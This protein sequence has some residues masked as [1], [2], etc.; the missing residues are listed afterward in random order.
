MATQMGTISAV[1]GEVFARNPQ[2]QVRRLRQGDPVF[3]GDVVVTSLGGSAD[4][5]PLAQGNP[6]HIAEGK[7]VGLDASVFN[8][9][10]LDPT[11]H[12]LEPL[13]I[14]QAATVIQQPAN[15]G[16]I[17]QLLEQEAAAAGLQGG[18][19][20]SGHSFVDLV[21][22]AE[23][24]APVAYDFPAN[25]VG[26]PP[27]IDGLAAP[28]PV[29]TTT[30]PV[31]AVT[32][33]APPVTPVTPETP[34]TPP[35]PTAPGWTGVAPSMTVYE[36]GLASG[37]NP[38]DTAAP[39]TASGTSSFTQGSGSFTAIVF[40][41]ATPTLTGY[42]GEAISWTLSND[43]HTL[44]GTVG[45]T[46]SITLTLMPN[47]VTGGFS[48]STTLSHAFKEAAG[49]NLQISGLGIRATD[50][51]GLSAQASAAV[52]VID[53]APAVSIYEGTD[54]ADHSATVVVGGTVSGHWSGNFGADGMSTT[55]APIVTYDGKDY[56][57]GTNIDTGK[58]TLTVNFDGSWTFVAA[59]GH[60]GET[61][62]FAIRVT[63]NDGDRAS[64]TMAISIQGA[65]TAPTAPGW[66][67]VAPSMT[68]YEAGLASGTNPG[69]TAAPITAS[70]T[71]S[72]TQGSGSFT[73]IVFTGAT[74]T[75]TGYAGEA[76][77]W[78]LSN[79][80]H[81]LTGTV[82]GTPS[83]TLTLMPN[84]VTGGFSVSTTLSH[85]FK[86]AAGAN[87]QISGLGIRATDS[88]GLSAQA[89]A[90]VTVID[91]APA[92]SIYEGTD[93]ADHSATVVVGG[94]VSG[95]WSGNFGADGMSTTFAPI[96]TYDGKDY[97]LGTNIDTGKGTLTVNFDGSW[98]F[99]AAAGHG[100][101]TV[102]FAIRVTDNDGDRASS[103]MAISIQGAPTV[104]TIN[105]FE[106]NDP[107]DH[108][109][110]ING[111]SSTSGH[112]TSTGV[113]SGTVQVQYGGQT[114]ALGQDI[115]TEYGTLRVNPDG[116][117]SFQ[118]TSP[119][120]LGQTA[121]PSFTLVA[122]DGDGDSASS[123]MNI[124]ISGV[125][126]LNQAPT[127]S[128]FGCFLAA[129]WD[130]H[131]Q[132]GT[133]LT[134]ISMS[135]PDADTVSIQSARIGAAGSQL[136][137]AE[138]V[139]VLHGQYL[140]VYINAQTGDIVYA[141]NGQA[142]P[143]N[144]KE[145]ISYTVSDEHGATTS[146][147]FDIDVQGHTQA[148]TPNLNPAAY[149]SI[150]G[151]AQSAVDADMVAAGF[152]LPNHAPEASAVN[153]I[154][155]ESWDFRVSQGVSMSDSDSGDTPRVLS[156][157]MGDW[158]MKTAGSDGVI[159]LHGQ[160]ADIYIQSQTGAVVCTWNGRAV[161]TGA[162]E[163]V[164][165]TVTDEHGATSSA[166]FDV[167]IQ[168]HEQAGVP[169]LESTPYAQLP[170]WAQTHIQETT[171]STSASETLEGHLGADTFVWTLGGI[172][173]ADRP[174]VDHVT[175]FAAGDTLQ[176]RDLLS[177]GN[178]LAVTAGESTTIAISDSAHN[179]VQTIVL[180]GYSTDSHTAELLRQT[181]QQ[182]QAY[183]AGG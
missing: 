131:S 132:A 11:A 127:T 136:A 120:A 59:A 49:A 176:L 28:A 9:A 22:I 24:V 6:L 142:V 133:A 58:G 158:S 68:V 170:S 75:L 7:T 113:G 80:G 109:A 67:G 153:V 3:E 57:L 179:V 66:T 74:P 167:T 81:T 117:W 55:F 44:T 97:A 90:A 41:G 19:E 35:A 92:V 138:G 144:A 20:E 69:D 161:P 83:I 76:I 122:T 15:T 173:S 1:Q 89:S 63:D 5:L 107:Q 172:G 70:G 182:S 37:T 164:S 45:G 31:E 53:D 156:A 147:H 140:N 100:G 171:Y 143:A 27:T 168:G 36:A 33:V 150:P 32:P 14:S 99:V 65:P 62:P 139:V 56:A 72:F 2:G 46:P 47:L 151:W 181:L 34:V 148:G 115:A 25:P 78:T 86:E 152:P 16:D 48:V 95:H 159:V 177:S 137:N 84:L 43:G 118:S 134:G 128:A 125:T 61:V 88:N 154:L 98:T 52:T 149:A 126:P 162:K 42:A 157:H 87:L 121:R 29:A 30:T 166:R 112:W 145:T 94:T 101:E 116:T 146:A 85:A 40:T 105:V 183:T 111:A 123:T 12:A 54:T 104:P 114:Y 178:S 39:I 165:Y 60:G 135:D 103:T 17:N 160:Y 175:G 51:N 73:A 130:F 8:A 50:S 129:N 18:G 10:T 21:R 110:N 77:S 141:W 119:G 91:D 106:N 96:V 38:G 79:D 26:T 64:S 174:A 4:V 180:D 13:S 108:Q 102:P 155:P 23:A 124:E 82:G 71:S 169:V 163:T 93:T